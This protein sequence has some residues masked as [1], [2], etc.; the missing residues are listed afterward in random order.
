MNSEAAHRG[1]SLPYANGK[2][3]DHTLTGIMVSIGI[4]TVFSLLYPRVEI[5]FSLAFLFILV[6]LL[7]ALAVGRAWQAI[8]RKK[9]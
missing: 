9:T 6:G 2:T 3:T 8:W 5:D 1:A 7:L 4:G